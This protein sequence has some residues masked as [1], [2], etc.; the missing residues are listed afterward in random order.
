[1]QSTNIFL[2]TY[3]KLYKI[4]NDLIYFDALCWSEG[5]LSIKYLLAPSQ[6]DKH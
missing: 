6:Q 5:V 1:M 3:M 2:L 4:N